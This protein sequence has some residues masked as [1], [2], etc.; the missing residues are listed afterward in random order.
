MV[1]EVATMQENWQESW[2]EGVAGWHDGE[3][4]PYSR[5]IT[6]LLYHSSIYCQVVIVK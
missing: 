4:R 1:S 5:E 6:A 3:G 2:K